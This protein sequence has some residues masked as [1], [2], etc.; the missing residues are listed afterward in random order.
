MGVFEVQGIVSAASGMPLVQFRQLDDEDEIVVGFQLE[1][2]EARDLA[3][4]IQE[5]ATNAIYEAALFNWAKERDPVNGEEMAAM[6]VDAVRRYRTD[7]WGLPSRPED[8][9]VG[10]NDDQ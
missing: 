3:Q 1:I 9:R 5:A 2:L 8:W 4:N 7:K 6:M 10:Q